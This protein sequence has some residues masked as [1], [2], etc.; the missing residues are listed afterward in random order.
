MEPFS[1]LCRA[2]N[3]KHSCKYRDA[4]EPQHTNEFNLIIG[5]LINLVGYLNYHGVIKSKSNNYQIDI[6]SLDHNLVNR[7]TQNS[8]WQ[9]QPLSL[10]I[11]EMQIVPD[12]VFTNGRNTIAIEI[13]KSNKKQSGLTWLN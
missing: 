2:T 12:G 11:Q 7:L 10:E 6:D 8:H 1:F 13:E 9:K 3:F 5:E 4:E